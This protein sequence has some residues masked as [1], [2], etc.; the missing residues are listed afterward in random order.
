[1]IVDV[2]TDNESLCCLLEDDCQLILF[3]DYDGVFPFDSYGNQNEL[4]NNLCL[5]PPDKKSWQWYLE[6]GRE[7]KG[8]ANIV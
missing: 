2:K 7:P 4:Y 5:R 6:E 3:T 8:E 1:M